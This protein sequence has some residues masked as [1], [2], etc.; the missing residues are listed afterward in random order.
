MPLINFE[1]NFILT[2]FEN[3]VLTSKT[4]RDSDPNADP[5]AAAI[6]NPTNATF[7]ITDTKLHVLVVTLSTAK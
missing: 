6:D 2:W 3:C 5:V 1:I 4:A 7:K